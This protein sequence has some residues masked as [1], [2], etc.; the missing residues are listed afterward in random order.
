MSTP[1]PVQVNGSADRTINAA[2]IP[3]V[4]TKELAREVHNELVALP[5]YTVFDNLAYRIDNGTVTLLGQV[6][7]P[8]LKTDAENVIS[9]IEGVLA[10]VN[11]ITVLPASPA[12]DSL[13]IALYR[14]I[15]ADADLSRYALQAVPP[16]HIVVSGGN[17]TLEGVVTTAADK[18]LAGVRAKAVPGI[19]DVTNNLQATGQ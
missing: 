2:E 13:R 18:N 9:K 10:V 12:D 3:T 11:N 1:T 15:Y 19:A 8:R 4:T 7:T 17:V 14:A 16:I 5:Y 6:T